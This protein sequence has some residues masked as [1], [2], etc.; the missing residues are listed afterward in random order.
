VFIGPVEDERQ[1][2]EMIGAPLL[3]SARLPA[4]PVDHRALVSLNLAFREPLLRF[5]Q[6]RV[7]D[8]LETE[9]LVQ[10]VFERLLRRGDVGE[11]RNW[12]SYAFETA[13]NVLRD[14][15]RRRRT[16][17][18]ETHQPFDSERHGG[19]D[20][21]PERI[22]LVREHLRATGNALAQL[23]DRTRSIFLLHR[24]GG[25]RHG[26]IAAQFGISVSAVEKHMGRASAHLA[27]ALESPGLDD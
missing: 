27:N 14:R 22:V 7:R 24:L 15:S 25:L 19:I 12:K 4:A 10:E 21:S 6:K 5:F 13:V 2:A 26:E 20:V 11:V 1:P 16:R 17:C 23:P 3:R 9:D 18:A 8:T